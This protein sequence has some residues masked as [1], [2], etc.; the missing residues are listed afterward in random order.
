MTSVCEPNRYILLLAKG[1]CIQYVLSK[2]CFRE[3]ETYHHKMYTKR[4]K[5]TW[6]I[7]CYSSRDVQYIQRGK[8]K[9]THW[10]T[11]KCWKYMNDYWFHPHVPI[12]AVKQGWHGEVRTLNPRRHP[13]LFHP[14]SLTGDWRGQQWDKRG[15]KHAYKNPDPFLDNYYFCFRLQYRIT[16]K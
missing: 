5:D 14:A 1:G 7:T 15:Q 10:N 11:Q 13:S 3:L 12:T 9:Q 16:I 2:L 4:L 8:A 6:R